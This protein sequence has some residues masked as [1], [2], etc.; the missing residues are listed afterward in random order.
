M[1]VYFAS[2]GESFKDLRDNPV[3]LVP[4]LLQ[5]VALILLAILLA[6][7]GLIILLPLTGLSLADFESKTAFLSALSSIAWT[8]GLIA[9]IVLVV[10]AILAPLIIVATWFN[11][12]ALAMINDVI[13]GRKTGSASF[14]AGARELLGRLL[15]FW[16]LSCL[17]YLIAAT[18]L[19]ILVGI[20]AFLGAGNKVALIILLVIFFLIFLVAA[21]FLGVALLFGP[22]IVVRERLGPAAAISRSFSLLKERPGHVI[23][24]FLMVIGVS[25]AV[26]LAFVILF[27]PLSVLAKAQPGSA[28]LQALNSGASLLHNVVSFILGI[29]LSL[30]IFRMY[31]AG[32]PPQ[33][34][35]KK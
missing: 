21:L 14:F 7:V 20:F 27:L 35:A 16:I 3:L 12:G 2:L 11:A 4:F 26:S 30:F 32:W 28:V 1:A 22:P 31:A 10:L 25:I 19:I 33:R 13:N 23:L 29:I 8:P 18:P 34:K 5:P 17:L 9:T 6:A 24:S 15:G